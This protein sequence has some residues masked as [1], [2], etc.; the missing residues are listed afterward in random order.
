MKVLVR[1]PNWIGDAIM[2]TPTLRALRAGFAQAE[3]VA[4]GRAGLLPLFAGAAWLDRAIAL[5]EERGALAPLRAGRLLRAEGFDLAVVLPNSWSSALAALAAGIPRRAGY[6]AQGRG[7]LLTDSLPVARQGRLRKIPMVEYYL[8]L[9]RRLGCPVERTGRRVELPVRPES[10]ERAAAWAR[11]RGLGAA[12]R[13]VALNVGAS[14]GPSKLWVTE[15]WA[16]VADHFLRS[17]RRVVLYGGP[18]D[19]PIVDA[20]LGAM[21]ERGA[22]AATDIPLGDL[23]AHLRRAAVLISTDSGGR[24]VGVAAG[25]PVVA[26]LGPTHPIYSETDHEKT[27]VLLEK[28]ECWPC[29]L[30]ECPIDHRCMTRI[31]PERVIAIAEAFLAGR[32]PEGG[33]R[34]WRTVPGREHEDWDAAA[35]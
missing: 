4:A 20:V 33:A 31:R 13:P 18:R 23:C 35:A 16:A 32:A 2:A 6:A 9:A 34:P 26:I 7:F 11:E 28:V 22:I 1:L 29:H 12:E 5:P 3:I 21:R 25:I 10:E 14:F 8:A 27:F 17:G 24:H 15:G 30:K 19:R